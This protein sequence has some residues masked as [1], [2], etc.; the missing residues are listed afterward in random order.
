[1]MINRVKL[2]KTQELIKNRMKKYLQFKNLTQC[3]IDETIVRGNYNVNDILILLN[4]KL[5][6]N[7]QQKLSDL[8]SQKEPKCIVFEGSYPLKI[9][10]PSQ[11]KDSSSKI[12]LLRTFANVLPNFQVEVNDKIEQDSDG[13]IKTNIQPNG[14]P[15]PIIFEKFFKL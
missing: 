2:A 7:N 15:R 14:K 3:E 12:F 10:V 11:L 6:T 5:S 1:M 4:S 13:K 8:F 9:V